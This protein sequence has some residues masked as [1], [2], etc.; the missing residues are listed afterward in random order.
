MNLQTLPADEKR[1]PAMLGSSVFLGRLLAGLLFGFIGIGV[2]RYTFLSP[3]ESAA[4][5]LF[6]KGG[7]GGAAATGDGVVASLLGKLFASFALGATAGCY[8]SFEIPTSHLQKARGFILGAF[9]FIIT[10]ALFIPVMTGDYIW[11]DDTEVT[12]NA[13]LRSNSGL[14]EI[15]TGGITTPGKGEK[16]AGLILRTLRPPL[17][18]IEKT[19]F[20]DDFVAHVS[21]DYFPLKSTFLWLQYRFFGLNATGY[22]VTNI[23]VH[24]LCTLLLWGV[25]R[26]LRVPGAWLG[27]LLFGIHPVHVESV[28]WISEGKNTWSLFFLTLSAASWLRYREAWLDGQ[29]ARGRYSASLLFYTASLLCK[30]SAIMFPF[31]LVL[32]AWWREECPRGDRRSWRALFMAALPFFVV[33]LLLGLVTIWFQNSR[34]IGGEVIPMGDFWSRLAGAGLAF[35]WYL[36]KAFL[37][38]QLTTIYPRWSFDPAQAQQLVAAALVPLGGLGLWLARGKVGRAPFFVYVFFFLMLFPVLGFFRMSYMRL[39]LVADHFQY[40]SNIAVVALVG[41]VV[42]LGLRRAPR[43]AAFGVLCGAGVALLAVASAYTWQ[44]AAVHY[45]EETLWTDALKHNW[46]SWQ[47]HN[48]LGAVYFNKYTRGGDSGAEFLEKAHTHFA[49]A[50]D[51]NPGNPEVHNNHALTLGA[52]GKPHAAFEAFRKSLEIDGAILTIRRNYAE[53]LLRQ[54]RYVD[55]LEQYRLL[56]DN[57]SAS[58]AVLMGFGKALYETGRLEGALAIYRDVVRA[59]PQ[60]RGALDNIRLIEARIEEMRRAGRLKETE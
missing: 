32:L 56:L 2:C 13:T 37:P 20:G 55:A 43:G 58:E 33:S 50:A 26:Q 22:H 3:G 42:T 57:R 60:N 30:T 6:L 29:R 54:E 36:G 24:A 7:A 11:D 8:F 21:S 47:S 15:W 49:K 39:T 40:L 1:I 45:N 48:H 44:R 38:I 28:A 4:L 18:K 27:A 34:A 51:L 59:N 10:T 14:W 17:Q 41:A 46:K 53:A 31:V 12:A 35:W 5:A 16:E 52:L 9:L 23:L 25:F 19:L